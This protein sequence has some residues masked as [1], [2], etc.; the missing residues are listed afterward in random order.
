MKFQLLIKA[1]MLKNKA[2]SCVQTFRCCMY[3]ADKFL[4]PTFVGN[5]TINEQDKFHAQLI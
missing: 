1:K 5:L 2:L 3:Y 4:M